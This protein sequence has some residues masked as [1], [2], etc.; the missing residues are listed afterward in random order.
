VRWV[1][2]ANASGRYDYGNGWQKCGGDKDMK[3]VQVFFVPLFLLPRFA[4][5]M[6]DKDVY[7]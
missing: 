6:Y 1:R 4:A 3:G 5:R 2:R 7:E